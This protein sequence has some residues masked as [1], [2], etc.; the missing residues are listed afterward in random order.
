MIYFRTAS[1]QDASIITHLV[2]S[3][4][5]GEYSKKGW[6]TEADL[7]E[8]QR[9]DQDS[10]IKMIE[11]K[12]EQIELA[13]DYSKKLLGCVYIKRENLDTLYFGMLTV[14][15]ILQGSGLGKTILLHL[16]NLARKEERTKIRLSVIPQR[17]ELIA[18]YERR[19]F[20]A[21]GKVEKFPSYDP[22]NGRPKVSDLELK[23]YI[24]VLAE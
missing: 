24:K 15:P 10:V 9:T 3:A 5:R 2:N 17:L 16:E 12:E 7:I 20:K 4:Y 22:S 6:T 1:I 11:A 19:G 14:D 23:E 13:F 21:T 18:F 8:G